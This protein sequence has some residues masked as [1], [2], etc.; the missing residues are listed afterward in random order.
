MRRIGRRGEDTALKNVISVIIAV[1]GI[2]AIVYGIVKVASIFT[3]QESTN[4]KN[5]LEV[6]GSRLEALQA[7]QKSTFLLQGFKNSENWIVASW[8]NTEN[9]RPDKCFF[10][11]CLCLCPASDN[12]AQ[13]CQ[14]SGFCKTFEYSGVVIEPINKEEIYNSPTWHESISFNLPVNADECRLEV[15]KDG[16]NEF[17]IV[18]MNPKKSTT[19]SNPELAGS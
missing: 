9:G 13:S 16:S 10:K 17:A 11:S 6:I 8:N 12:N 18:Q 1:I 4:A 7:G 3:N 5:S 19:F 14:A 2:V 15:V